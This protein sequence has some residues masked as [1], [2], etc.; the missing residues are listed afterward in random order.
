[1]EHKINETIAVHRRA[2]GL[3]QEQLGAKLGVSGQAVSK[4]EKGESMPDILLLPE[5][6]DIF[7]VT[8]DKL[9]GHKTNESRNIMQEFCAMARREGRTKTLL[10]ALGS[11][12][13]DVGANHGG[14]N[15]QISPDNIRIYNGA[16]GSS[17]E[18]MGFLLSGSA[19]QQELRSLNTADAADFLRPLGDKTTLDLLRHTSFDRAVTSTELCEAVGIDMETVECILFALMKRNILCFDTDP[20]G[21]RGYLQAHGMPGVYMALAG[22]AQANFGG[23]LRG[24]LWMTRLADR[25]S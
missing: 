22:C 25:K 17:G 12:F 20:S 6:C 2:L 23:E 21:K 7:G 13:N 16:Q 5:L 8:V 15:T 24:N 1:M 19:A 3:T 9:L 14:E 10:D 11:L 18:G 4:W